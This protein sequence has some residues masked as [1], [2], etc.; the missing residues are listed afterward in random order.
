MV[1]KKTILL[2]LILV[3]VNCFSQD[4]EN[5]DITNVTKVTFWSPGMSYEKRIGKFQSLYARVFISWAFS[6]GGSSS[7]D[8]I[9]GDFYVDPTL[10]LNYRYYYN[11]SRRAANGKRTELNSSNYFS[12]IFEA[13]FTKGSLSSSDLI[14]KNRRPIKTFGIVW[15]FQRN[16]TKRFS[17]DLNLGAGFFY[18]KSTAI[19][20]AGELTKKTV[21]HFSSTGRLNLGFWLNKKH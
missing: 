1:F 16:Y 11:F 3:S 14:E 12:P 7:S 10:T 8:G 6:I 21:G 4:E 9:L 2:L 19:N 5:T 20:N 17:L 18:G 15:G 13:L